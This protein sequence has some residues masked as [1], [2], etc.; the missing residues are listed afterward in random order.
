MAV[1]RVTTAPRRGVAVSSQQLLGFVGGN[2][3]RPEVAR[4]E[5]LARGWLRLW[6]SVTLRVVAD[7]VLYDGVCGLCD[8]FTRFILARDRKGRFVFASLQSEVA[9]TLLARHGRDPRRLE[10]VYVCAEYGSQQEKL[11]TKSRAVLFVLRALG[12]PWALSRAAAVLPTRF[13]DVIYDWI[14]ARR[15]RMFGRSD[16]CML[17]PREQRA[18][19]IDV[20]AAPGDG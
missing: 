20:G 18:R 13:L 1:A 7:L 10:T 14:A 2:L 19:F 12:G 5:T 6:R 17:P 3:A 11:Y 4:Q 15:Y 16:V 9:E 8:R